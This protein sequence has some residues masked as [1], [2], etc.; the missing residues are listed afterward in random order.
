MMREQLI[1]PAAP[2]G[3]LLDPSI[4]PRGPR[5]ELMSGKRVDRYTFIETSLFWGMCVQTFYTN[6]L[7]FVCVCLYLFVPD[8]TC[9]NVLHIPD[10][11]TGHLTPVRDSERP[12]NYHNYYI[13]YFSHP[14]HTQRTPGRECSFWS[15]AVTKHRKGLT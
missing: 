7:C 10:D 11:K 8:W 15:I 6:L 5:N 2:A 1:D 4:S 3:S 13:L 12:G 9:S 14:S